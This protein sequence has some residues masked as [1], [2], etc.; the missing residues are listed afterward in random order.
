MR[1][2]AIVIHPYHPAWPEHFAE[3][4]D[5]VTPVLRPWLARD[6]EHMGSTAVPGLPAKDIVDMLAVVHEID[7]VD[8]AIGPMGE[9]GWRHAPEPADARERRLSFCFP[10]VERRSHHLHVVEERSDDWR[11]WLAFRDH[12]RSHPDVARDYAELK[13]ALADAHGGD[14]NQRDGYRAGKSTFVRDVTERA[15]GR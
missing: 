7:G 15:L 1:L 13:S 3:Q 5:A 11:G 14:P 12:L 9:I 8:A 6:I 2:D 4:R 10:T